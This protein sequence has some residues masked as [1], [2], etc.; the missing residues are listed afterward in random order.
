MQVYIFNISRSRPAFL[1]KGITIDDLQEIGKPP[2]V[3]H[4]FTMG[5]RMGKIACIWDISN[6]MGNLLR[7]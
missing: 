5:S 6:L 2:V 4:R 3:K 1:I 7:F